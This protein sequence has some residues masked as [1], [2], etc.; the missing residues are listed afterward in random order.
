METAK[1]MLERI[2]KRM[3]TEPFPVVLTKWQW[4]QVVGI[5]NEAYKAGATDDEDIRWASVLALK[6]ALGIG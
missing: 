3:E 2:R 6:S 5:C 4:A 1:E